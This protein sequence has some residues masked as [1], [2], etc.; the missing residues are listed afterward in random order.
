MVN[1]IKKLNI[2]P[3]EA[4]TLKIDTATMMEGIN[5]TIIE[6]AMANADSQMY[7]TSSH[8]IYN[9]G[10]YRKTSD[11]DFAVPV[12]KFDTLANDLLAAIPESREPHLASGEGI[13][14]I[15]AITP[16]GKTRAHIFDIHEVDPN[17]PAGKLYTP[18]DYYVNR[19]ID[20]L[21]TDQ[22]TYPRT[23][24]TI[25][26]YSKIQIPGS[27]GTVLVEP[28]YS[29]IGRK[30]QAVFQP[31]L[32]EVS[33]TLSPQM[34][35]TPK[36]V[37]YTTKIDLASY[38]RDGIVH[39][40]P[41]GDV[42]FRL[43]AP[44]S[45]SYKTARALGTIGN[46]PAKIKNLKGGSLRDKLSNMGYGVSELTKRINLIPENA[47]AHR[48]KDSL[49][50]IGIGYEATTHLI[51]ENT[52]NPVKKVLVTRAISKDLDKLTSDPY[53]S[54][55]ARKGAIDKLDDLS[56]DFAKYL[57]EKGILRDYTYEFYLVKQVKRAE[58]ANEAKK[59]A[60]INEKIDIS[61]KAL[62]SIDS[63]TNTKPFAILPV[64]DKI[65]YA[66]SSSLQKNY[67]R[68][69][70]KR[71]EP[72]SSSEYNAANKKPQTYKPAASPYTPPA[73]PSSTGK[74]PTYT[75]PAYQTF[76]S[77]Y[78]SQTIAKTTPKST[79]PNQPIL[80]SYTA[81]SYKLPAVTQPKR[82]KDDLDDDLFKRY[83]PLRREV[84]HHLSIIDP[85]EAINAG[86]FTGSRKRP[87]RIINT[88]N[89][90]YEISS[91]SR[92][93]RSRRT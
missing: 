27:L 73:T 92:T 54:A 62:G 57:Y 8:A 78:S 34:Y 17:T 58:L 23:P 86:S 60:Y 87:E 72:Q 4:G 16:S 5:P 63:P 70:I 47:D 93:K 90:I 52:I 89:L 82:K 74:S 48:G 22:T 26:E 53:F 33:L 77:P 35:K 75:P 61:T 32:G 84:L 49:D 25:D 21:E 24:K 36:Q 79:L 76:N 50:I 31:R 12:E 37:V 85:A 46:I 39:D 67:G 55:I 91:T 11:I 51:A 13:R 56:P 59:T 18:N 1:Q 29:A 41:D 43:L 88:K 45:I 40:L 71:K 81:P 2:D 64:V 80:K 44:K 14:G 19:G 68:Y 10:N 30:F 83:K 38:K 3:V 66:P 7:G 6:R 20:L 69:S 15:S 42:N 65:P 9:M 28:A